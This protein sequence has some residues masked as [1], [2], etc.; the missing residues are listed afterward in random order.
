MLFYPSA[1]SLEIGWLSAKNQ[2]SLPLSHSVALCL[3]G[4]ISGG[5]WTGWTNGEVMSGWI[6][7]AEGNGLLLLRVCEVNC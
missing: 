3:C 1:L 2:N 7:V 5:F 4:G 6:S